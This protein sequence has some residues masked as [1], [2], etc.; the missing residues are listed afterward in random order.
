MNTLE[1]MIR[2]LPVAMKLS[3][4]RGEQS[5]LSAEYSLAGAALNLAIAL[6]EVAADYDLEELEKENAARAEAMESYHRRHWQSVRSDLA[7]NNGP[8]S[9]SGKI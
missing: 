9:G 5:G 2:V 7:W 8:L 6:R 3:D 4:S 1:I